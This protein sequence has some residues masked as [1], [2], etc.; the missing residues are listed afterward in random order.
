MGRGAWGSGCRARGWASGGDTVSGEV[1]EAT[2]TFVDL[3]FDE[4]AGDVSVGGVRAGADVRAVRG[5]V[6]VATGD[7]RLGVWV[8]R[9]WETSGPGACGRGGA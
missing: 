3:L 2:L 1:A 7:W 9:M 8:D 6:W 5:G 4:A